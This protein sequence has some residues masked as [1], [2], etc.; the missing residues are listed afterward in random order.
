MIRLASSGGTEHPALCREHDKSI[1]LTKPI[2]QLELLDA[3]RTA[4]GA[5]SRVQMSAAPGQ[6]DNMAKDDR[7]L[8]ILLAEDNLVNQRLALRLLQKRG[9]KVTLAQNGREAL[10]TLQNEAFDLAL[11]DV[12]MPEMDGLTATAA[13]REREK[14]SGKRL[15]IVAMTAHAMRG[16]E[17][18]CLA[19]GM[20]EYISKPVNADKLSQII[21]RIACRAPQAVAGQTAPTGSNVSIGQ[22][23]EGD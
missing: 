4:L 6:L 2:R 8:K 1:S 23:S 7:P 18:R 17:E 9:H 20:D 19:A 21:E 10:A 14:A 15:P 11:M 16:D 12:E 3:A 13:I 22:A 5:K